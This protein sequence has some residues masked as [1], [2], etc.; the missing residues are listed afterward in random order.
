M[1]DDKSASSKNNAQNS[2]HPNISH[3][4]TLKS[5]VK[6]VFKN[7]LKTKNVDHQFLKILFGVVIKFAEQFLVKTTYGAANEVNE[8]ATSM[9]DNGI[10][11]AGG[12]NVGETGTETQKYRP[13]DSNIDFEFQALIATTANTEIKYW[14]ELGNVID[15]TNH[16]NSNSNPTEHLSKFQKFDAEHFHNCLKIVEKFNN[17][18][19]FVE[20][21]DDSCEEEFEDGMGISDENMEHIFRADEFATKT[22]LSLVQHLRKIFGFEI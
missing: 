11:D 12:Q 13:N 7:I 17:L 5:K 10:D 20:E 19:E 6:N 1:K 3:L 16:P 18:L 9:G 22:M 4:P 14:V 8:I 15:S 2:T 21:L